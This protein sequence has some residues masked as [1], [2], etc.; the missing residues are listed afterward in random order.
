MIPNRHRSAAKEQ[1]Q[2][3]AAEATAAAIGPAV[4]PTEQFRTELKAALLREFARAQHTVKASDTAGTKDEPLDPPTVVEVAS[5]HG[6][7]RLANVE[8]VSDEQAAE[9]VA[10]LERIVER[11][12]SRSRHA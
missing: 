12:D 10:A 3:V 6:T 11:H 9:A 8:A 4:F 1:A 7:V 2:A 5:D